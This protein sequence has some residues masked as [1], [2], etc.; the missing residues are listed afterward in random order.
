MKKVLIISSLLF[1]AGL[2]FVG[3]NNSSPNNVAG[4]KVYNQSSYAE[5]A[6]VQTQTPEPK[7]EVAPVQP[8]PQPTITTQKVETRIP[9]GTPNGT[10]TNVNGNEVPRPYHAPSAP[11]GATAQCRDG[12]YSFSQHRSG[13]CSHHGGVSRWL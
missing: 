8:V 5:T 3:G 13:T 6:T 11:A 4:E 1:W 7:V 9:V 2:I 10:Y 12:S